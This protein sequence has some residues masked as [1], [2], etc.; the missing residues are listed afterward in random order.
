MGRD[1]CSSRVFNGAFSLQ[2]PPTFSLG[3]ESSAG[4]VSIFHTTGTAT[5]E[6]NN[7]PLTWPNHRLSKES[8]CCLF[9]TA[10]VT[11]LSPTSLALH[12]DTPEKRFR[13]YSLKSTMHTMPPS[14]AY[15][16][17]VTSL[18]DQPCW[19]LRSPACVISLG[20]SNSVLERNWEISGKQLCLHNELGVPFPE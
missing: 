12:R 17:P 5:G 4:S 8:K 7:H 9:Q 11:A 15:S 19:A 10:L 18:S 3:Q 16:R 1:L 14:Y 6:P 13:C 2:V 20:T